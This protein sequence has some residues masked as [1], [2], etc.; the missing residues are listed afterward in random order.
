MGVE[1]VIIVGAGPAGIAAAIQLKRYDMQP[2]LFERGH[3]GGL[4]HNAN[5]VENYPGFPGGISGPA[6]VDLFVHQ[7]Q[8]LHIEVTYEEVL[9][10]GFDQDL[11]QVTTRR[12]TYSSRVL[13]IAT[14]TQPLHFKGMEIPPELTDKV[15]YEVYD[16]LHLE[17]Q[18]IAVVGS[19]DA[20]FDYALN[21]SRKNQVVILNR[22]HQAKCLPLL[23]ERAAHIAS[24]SYHDNIT[25]CQLRPDPAGGMWLDCQSEAGEI[26]YHADFL[27]GAIGRE[28]CLECLS[29]AVRQDEQRLSQQ[30]VLYMIGDVKNGIYRQTSIA[31]GDGVMA[32]MKIYHK[33]QE[34]VS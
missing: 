27:L 25:L 28:A 23:R 5:L 21:L 12:N 10:V 15:F 29:P 26:Q 2:R 18:C 20:A 32:A 11:F 22:S 9:E 14:G 19:G 8:D 1:Q 7:A 13:I 17:D 4:L 3:M 31:V 30:G 33:L 24:I 6:L 16:L 34:M